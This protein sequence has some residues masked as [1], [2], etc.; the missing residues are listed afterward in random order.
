[1]LVACST[2]QSKVSTPRNQLKTGQLNEATEGFK[3]LAEQPSDDQLIYLLDYATALQVTGRYKESNEIFLKA[4]KLADLQNYFSVSRITMATLGGEEMTQYKGESYEIILINVMMALNYIMLNQPD[5]AMVEVR[6]LNEKINRIRL[7]GRSDYEQN[8]FAHYLMGVIYEMDKKYDDAYIAYEDSYKLNYNNPFLAGDLI[9]S[10]KKSKRM[11]SYKKW[12]EE[13]KNVE[14]S[15]E[16]YDKNAGELIIFA[17]QG[18]GPEKDYAYGN[19]RFPQLRPQRSATQFVQIFVDDKEKSKTDLVYDVEH[20]AIKTLNDDYGWLIARRMA[21]RVAKEVAADQ[22]R[23]KNEALGGI[24]KLAMLISDRADLRQWSTLPQTIQMS[25][26]FLKPGSYKIRLQ[27][28]SGTSSST[29]DMK[30]ESEVRIESGKKNILVW[31][32][33]R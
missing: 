24:L 7:E 17:E 23:Q 9:R 8:P 28:M 29:A 5:E 32:A 18:W 21:A 26:F 31:R 3:K 16:W 13:F 10:A 19:Y 1:M 6:R 27:G 30:E 15:S 22:V 25:R 2:Y 11:D 33:L 4:D 14:E 20:V 12:K